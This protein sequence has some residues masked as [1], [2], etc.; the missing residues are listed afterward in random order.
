MRDSTAKILSA[1]HALLYRT[2][3]GSIGKRL[4]NNDMLLLTTRGRRTGQ[5]H[6]VPL[7]YLTHDQGWVVIASWGG[8]TY[9]PDW[10]LNLMADPV[11]EIQFGGVRTSVSAS[12]ADPGQR[13]DLWPRIVAAYAGYS[14]YAK[15]TKRE[16][17]VVLLKPLI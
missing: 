6:T 15:R 11:A 10:Y 14:D 8:R 5:P 17:P 2:T 7:L 4:V 13:D 12:T 3:R 1:F 9:D 16:I